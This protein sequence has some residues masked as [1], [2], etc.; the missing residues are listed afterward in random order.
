MENRLRTVASGDG[1]SAKPEDLVQ[2]TLALLACRSPCRER[3]L[4]DSGEMP[5]QMLQSP[6]RRRSSGQQQHGFRIALIDKAQNSLSR[7]CMAQHAE[8]QGV[9]ESRL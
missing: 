4:N 1:E 2:A 3:E 8:F 5:L 6:R 9:V 7:D